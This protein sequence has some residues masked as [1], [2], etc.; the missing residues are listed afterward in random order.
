MLSYS[1]SSLFWL[2]NRVSNFA[3]LRYNRIAKQVREVAD[4]WENDHLQEVQQIIAQGKSLSAK[5]RT[6][7]L[8]DY[9]V[10][11]AEA[12]FDKWKAL[13]TYLLVKYIDGN[14]KGESAPGKFKDNGFDA[15]IPGDIQQPGYD[16]K[17][18]RAVVEDNG[19]VLQVIE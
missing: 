1:D 4:A 15:G 16:A 10:A 8:T 2:F 5:R 12:L 13:D 11:Q 14:V 19:A 6:K 9:S 17:W 3:Y 7:L 18:Q